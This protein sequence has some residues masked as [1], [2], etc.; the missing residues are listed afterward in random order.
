ARCSAAATA[1]GPAWA[2]PV[3]GASGAAPLGAQA[4]VLKP[5]G[6]TLP[7]VARAVADAAEGA[8]RRGESVVDVLDA[9]RTAGRAA[10]ARTPD[11][12]PVPRD[13]GVGDA[14]GAGFVPLPHAP[15]P[16]VD[17][18][19]GPHPPAGARAALS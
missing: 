6:G 2:P 11:L 10:L 18:R 8:A 1:R 16:V 17:G 3:P 4:A 19:A 13:A 14:G 12:L 7:T 15:L 5:G 9:A